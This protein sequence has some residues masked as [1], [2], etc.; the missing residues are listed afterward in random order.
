VIAR[1]Y[2]RMSDE[3]RAG[4]GL[5]R[6]AQAVCDVVQRQAVTTYSK[7]ADE[8][9]EELL[10]GGGGG[11]AEYYA[12]QQPAA[13]SAISSATTTIPGSGGSGSSSRWRSAEE[14]SRG[15]VS[16]PGSGASL[17]PHSE[18]GPSEERNIRRRVYDALNVLEAVQVISRQQKVLRWIGLPEHL[19]AA[20]V[21][22]RTEAHATLHRIEE[23]R[24][25]LTDMLVEQVCLKN[26]IEHNKRTAALAAALQAKE[27]AGMPAAAATA[28][29]GAAA[30]ASTAMA[31][32][33]T[34]VKT[35]LLP[36]TGGAALIASPLDRSS[37][38]QRHAATALL[39]R[40]PALQRHHS[41]F[42]SRLRQ[43]AL[44]N[45]SPGKDAAAAAAAAGA[46]PPA[47]P[48]PA[49]DAAASTAALAGSP[50]ASAS[51]SS[52]SSLQLQSPPLP[53]LLLSTPRSSVVFVE[54]SDDRT[55]VALHVEQQADGG[56]KNEGPSELLEHGQL[57]RALHFDRVRAWDL[58][59]FLPSRNL[60]A[61]Y[62]PEAIIHEPT[63]PHFVQMQQQQQQQQ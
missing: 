55:Q 17:H 31:A 7:V 34:P 43:A 32:P 33:V 23:K 53:F 46:A 45:S 50:G 29:S 15:V 48:S 47:H 3:G 26:L 57:L 60:C 18:R 24:Q 6:F 2:V 10:E 39:L 14:D 37:A 38:A 52:S 62:P 58:P 36:N 9:V 1:W 40:S 19:R 5:R 54:Q 63:P 20:T 35:P 25:Q 21:Q 44:R 56:D 61:L 27:A 59:R 22:A 4:K 28:A 41:P 51:S 16:A 8:L 42:L 11:T 12:A 30:S 49:K 13:P